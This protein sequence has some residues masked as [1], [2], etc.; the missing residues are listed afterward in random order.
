MGIYAYSDCISELE[1]KADKKKKGKF[2]DVI[3]GMFVAV[4]N[5]LF[6]LLH[7]SVLLLLSSSPS[8]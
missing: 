1:C 7:K 3:Y 5:W 8:E 6:C 4:N 2:F